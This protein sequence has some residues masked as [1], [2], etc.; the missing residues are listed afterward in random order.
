M[1]AKDAIHKTEE[2]TASIETSKKLGGA[3]EEIGKINGTVKRITYETHILSINAAVEAA[4]A[5][6]FGLGFSVVAREIKSLAEN[7]NSSAKMIE[8]II[9]KIQ[10]M[11]VETIRAI[12]D[13]GVNVQYGSQKIEDVYQELRQILENI[14]TIDIRIG[15]VS[16]KMQEQSDTFVKISSTLDTIND[17][18]SQIT[19]SIQSVL[20]NIEKQSKATKKLNDTSL[21][22]NE[23][24]EELHKMV[25]AILDDSACEISGAP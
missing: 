16:T 15:T 17:S 12:S 7:T 6:Q 20:E 9:G 2:I 10:S 19:H 13:V 25:A 22:L 21:A 4:R 24:S 3:A 8:S 11:V 5:G 14:S 18:N 1:D 23:S